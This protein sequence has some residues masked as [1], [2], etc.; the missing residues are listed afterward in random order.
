MSGL[1]RE[2][3]KI[4]TFYAQNENRELY[5]NYLSK[6]NGNDGYGLLA[7]GVVRNDTPPGATANIFADNRAHK[8]GIKMSEREW[9]QFGV[10]LIRNDLDER[11][12][13]LNAGRPDLALN[14][15]VRDVQDA[16]DHTFQ[17][18][19]IDPNAWT[20]REFLQAARRHGGEG[21][22]EKAWTM[23]LDNS[24]LGLNRARETSWRTMYTYNDQ[25][26]DAGSYMGHMAEARGVATQAQPNTDP[27]RIGGKSSY[28]EYD[29]HTRQWN[30]VTF[31]G[32]ITTYQPIHDSDKLRLLND[33]RQ[34]R[35]ERQELKH[36]FHPNDPYRNLPITR[37]PVLLSENAPPSSSES[38]A[39]AVSL[40]SYAPDQPSHPRFALYQQCSAGVDVLDREFGR[41]SDQSSACMKASLTTLAVA[42]GLE[43][44][45]HVLLSRS[46]DQTQSGQTVYV[47]QG[48]PGNPAHLRAQMPTGQAVTTPVEASFRELAQI[49]QR[50]Q[51]QQQNAQT[52]AQQQ[53]AP[54]Q[55][56]RTQSV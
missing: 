2:D 48:D 4:L 46:S 6:K 26:L 16:H 19:R 11:R 52:L 38:L 7:L 15:P 5:W 18:H 49:D 47:V 36:E 28:S 31:T 22:A 14:L 50:Q 8:G 24:A 27:D 23:M 42:N 37:S 32:D 1:N 56:G 34:L 12:S 9:N 33:T 51:L 41:Q 43:R 54:T 39:R 45:D 30:D 44:V 17:L 40:A 29:K 13:Q 3:L 55:G 10:D 53:E 21:E 20:P 25:H 35:L